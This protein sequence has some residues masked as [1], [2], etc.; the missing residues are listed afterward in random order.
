MRASLGA[1]GP[2]DESMVGTGRLELPTSCVSSRRSNQAELRAY[3]RSP[4]L[5]EDA[6]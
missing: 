1:F 3:M 4:G 6:V 2:E 5:T